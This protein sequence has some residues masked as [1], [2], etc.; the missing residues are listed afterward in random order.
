MAKPKKTTIWITVVI[1]VL[2]AIIIT[3]ALLNQ[4]S[5]NQ[6]SDSVTV[7]IAGNED[8]VYTF[9][10]LNT[11]DGIITMNKTIKSGSREDETADFTGILVK[12]LLLKTTTQDVLENASS[13]T[14]ISGDGYATSY[15]IDEILEDD[16]ILLVF[17]QDGEKLISF[18]DGGSGPLRIVVMK[19]EFGTRSAMWVN[20]IVLE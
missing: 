12:D 13:V 19:D 17:L 14:A 3:F 20:Q 7:K 2:I 15:S 5:A 6:T 10:D 9:D 11:M 1:I 18:S 16:N 8:V 4:N